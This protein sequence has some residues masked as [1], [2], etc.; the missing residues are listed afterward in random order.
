MSYEQI[1]QLVPQ[2]YPFIFV[3]RVLEIE[4]G[5]RI[6]CLKNVT[7]NEYFFTGHFP[8]FS[9]MP[10]ALIIEALAQSAILLFRTSHYWTEEH[11]DKMFL[12]RAADVH[13][14]HPVFPGDQLILEVTKEKAAS[15]GAIVS[16]LGRVGDKT[17]AKGSL[18]FGAVKKETF[19]ALESGV[20]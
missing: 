9:I 14:L 13:F 18:M 15:I 12:L 4:S 5:K 19:L 16:V 1:K 3:D 7:A 6:L 8:D 20:K 2:K 11:A 10:G 17:V